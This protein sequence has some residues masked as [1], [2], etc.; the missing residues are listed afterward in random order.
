M[1]N[2]YLAELW[3]LKQALL[4]SIK[5]FDC[6]IESLPLDLLFLPSFQNQADRLFLCE[7]LDRYAIQNNCS[8]KKVVNATQELNEMH[9]GLGIW[10]N[11]KH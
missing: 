4:L 5:D 11:S 2:N 6:N 7:F 8:V 9:L 3:I 1:M 10:E